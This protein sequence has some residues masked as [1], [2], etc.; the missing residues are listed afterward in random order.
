MKVAICLAL[1]AVALVSSAPSP[2]TDAD[3]GVWPKPTC[4][5]GCG[6]HLERICKKGT[7]CIGWGNRKYVRCEAKDSLPCPG[8]NGKPKCSNFDD[9]I[10]NQWLN[11]GWCQPH[12]AH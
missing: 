8:T 7:W 5:K 3:A 6:R 10:C 4:R 1:F 2:D 12:S 9:K 11:E